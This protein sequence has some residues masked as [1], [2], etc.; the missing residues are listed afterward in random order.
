MSHEPW[1]LIGSG[2]CFGIALVCFLY[3][4]I[5]VVIDHHSKR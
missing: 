1:R 2:M 3:A 4:L 5:Y